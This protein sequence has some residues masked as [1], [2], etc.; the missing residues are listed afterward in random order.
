MIHNTVNFQ[1]TKSA[2]CIMLRNETDTLKL[3]FT[4]KNWI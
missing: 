2:Y 4:N 3:N 1:H